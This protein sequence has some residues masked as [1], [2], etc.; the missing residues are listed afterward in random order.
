MPVAREGCS[1][2]KHETLAFWAFVLCMGRDL[3]LEIGKIPRAS[4]SF[5]SP[6]LAIDAKRVNGG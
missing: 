5:R 1:L 4:L 3:S 6:V 2:S